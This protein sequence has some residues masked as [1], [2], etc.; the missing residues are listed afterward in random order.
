[1]TRGEYGGIVTNDKAEI[2]KEDGTI[3]GRIKKALDTWTD[4]GI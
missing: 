1:M 3:I 2:V 4:Q